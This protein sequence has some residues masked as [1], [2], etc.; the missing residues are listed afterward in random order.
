M[1]HAVRLR[2]ELGALLDGLVR[3]LRPAV[4][5]LAVVACGFL[6]AT[7]AFGHGG[8]IHVSQ[9]AAGTAAAGQTITTP[10]QASQWLARSS[11]A[12]GTSPVAATQAG[13]LPAD[14]PGALASAPIFHVDMGDGSACLVLLTGLSSCG[15]VP[16]TDHPVVGVTA[17]VDGPGGSLP[18]VAVAS[19]S[20][21]VTD[22]TF[23]CPG[24]T[25]DATIKNGLMTLV[26]SASLGDPGACTARAALTNGGT[27]TWSFSR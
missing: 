16:D 2:N 13:S 15:L 14:A 9:A 19:V 1:Q 23:T 18:F 26:A 6:A 22:V 12:L 27:W 25:A 17:D 20:D 7:V 4:G 5:L 10:D 21:T 3:G 11:S 8:A 24:G